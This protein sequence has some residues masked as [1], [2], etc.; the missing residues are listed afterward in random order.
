MVWKKNSHMG[1][2]ELIQ[3]AIVVYCH[4]SHRVG[5]IWSNDSNSKKRP[6]INI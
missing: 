1:I 4:T 2:K 3:N 6:P 5:K